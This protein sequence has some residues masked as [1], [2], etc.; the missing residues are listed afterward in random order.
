LK[1]GVDYE[2]EEDDGNDDRTTKSK[3]RD[4]VY[5]LSN[6]SKILAS[7]IEERIENS[8]RAM[9]LF[10]R[11]LQDADVDLLPTEADAN[12]VFQ[13]LGKNFMA[14]EKPMEVN[15]GYIIRGV[16]KRKTAKELLDVLDAKL[17]KATIDDNSQLW[18]DRY[19]V[20][21]VEIY[22]DTNDELF[23]DALL[24]TPNYF[25][26]LAPKLLSVISSSIALFSS[27]VYCINTFGG[28]T[29]VMQRL[30]EASES[31]TAGGMGMG[32]LAWFNDLLIP[33]LAT[34]GL[35][36]GVH[37]MAHIL[38][39]WSKE[40]RDYGGYIKESAHSSLRF[41]LHFAFPRHQVKLTAPTVLPSLGLPYLSFQNRIKTSPK[42]Y[43]DLFDIA[44]VGPIAGLT[45]SFVALLV[46][47][48]LTTTVD[49]TTAQLLPCLPVGY[50]TQSTLGGTIVDLVLGGGDGLLL[51]QDAST[52]VPLHPVAIAGFL[53]LIIHALDFVPVGSADGGRM[54]Q[55]VLGRVWHLT[56]SSLV[57]LVLFISS[58]TTDSNILLGYLFVYS[59]TQRD[60]E[61][62]CRNEVDK[63]ELPRAVAALVSWLLAALIL[64]PL[65]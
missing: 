41:I 9:E 4:E 37:E 1:G 65:R 43:S 26:P 40:V 15:G 16:N 14:T 53:G 51:N 34:L 32:E 28:N 24:I 56:F 27:F 33:L 63:V 54:S 29:V 49:P 20:S 18:Q 13:V 58:L 5:E 62:P 61:I 6:M 45:V 35:A 48:E 10:P 55:A 46:G 2:D 38:V 52:Q 57:F 23:E 59:F 12:V 17:A 36:Q 22:S 11:S 39:A 25:T 60:M 8:T 31:A 64:V 47:L 3:D 19:Q 50:L 7:K 21:F 30:K 42:G 44:F